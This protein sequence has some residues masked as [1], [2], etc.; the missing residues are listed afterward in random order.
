[1]DEPAIPLR[2]TPRGCGSKAEPRFPFL[3]YL[4]AGLPTGLSFPIELL[5]NGGGPAKV[6]Q[7]QNL[8]FEDAAFG[9][10]GQQITDPNLA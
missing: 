5:G 2:R 7:I 6:G 10:D 3:G 9:L 1:M 8:D 4:P